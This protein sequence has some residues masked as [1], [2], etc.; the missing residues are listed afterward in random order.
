MPKPASAGSKE[1]AWTADSGKKIDIERFVF[2]PARPG[3]V[4]RRSLEKA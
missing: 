1:P 2:S 4:N 3:L